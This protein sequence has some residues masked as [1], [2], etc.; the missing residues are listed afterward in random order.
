MP[1]ASSWALGY[2]QAQTAASYMHQ[3]PHELPCANGLEGSCSKFHG[4]KTLSIR[5]IG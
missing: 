1:S 5:A 4:I 3:T 2:R